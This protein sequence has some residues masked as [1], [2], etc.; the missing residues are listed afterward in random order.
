MKAKVAI[1]WTGRCL[2]V[3]EAERCGI[4]RAHAEV[5]QFE[6]ILGLR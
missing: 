2:D 1:P 6:S 4:S 3:L 5:E